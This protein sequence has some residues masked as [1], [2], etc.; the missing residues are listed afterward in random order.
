[1]ASDNQNV[2]TCTA[3]LSTNK[4]NRKLR[5]MKYCRLACVCVDV[6]EAFWIARRY[7]EGESLVGIQVGVLRSDLQY[8]SV[9]RRVFR[10]LRVVDGLQTQRYVVVYVSDRYVHLQHTSGTFYRLTL[11]GAL[12][13]LYL[14]LCYQT[15]DA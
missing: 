15:D 4:K 3:Q 12:T 11:H 6:E 2:F 7:P 5:L 1:M 10:N 9:R 14:N 13:I 8:R